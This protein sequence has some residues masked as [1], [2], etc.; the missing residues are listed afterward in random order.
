M[1]NELKIKE[2]IAKCLGGGYVSDYETDKVYQLF[3]PALTELERWSKWD[4]SN[5][6]VIN[7][8]NGD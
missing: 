8:L 7:Q 6:K 2:K 1:L 5:A 4:D 3:L